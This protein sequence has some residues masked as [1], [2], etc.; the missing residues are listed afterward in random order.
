MNLN[1]FP[2]GLRGHVVPVPRR[3]SNLQTQ[4]FVRLGHLCAD[5][6]KCKEVSPGKLY[7]LFGEEKTIFLKTALEHCTISQEPL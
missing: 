2:P 4:G 5:F 7:L 6:W 3:A 1:K